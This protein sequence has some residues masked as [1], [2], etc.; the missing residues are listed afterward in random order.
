[1]EDVNSKRKRKEEAKML[2]RKRIEESGGIRPRNTNNRKDEAPTAT[3]AAT[4]AATATTTSNGSKSIITNTDRTTSFKKKQFEPSS[5]HRFGRVMESVPCRKQPRYST[6]SIALPGSVVSNCQTRELKT[7]LVGQIARA[8]AVYHVDEIIV[9][10]DKLAEDK[11]DKGFFRNKHR[12]ETKQREKEEKKEE[13][14]EEEPKEEKKEEPSD[15]PRFKRSDPH[16]FMARVLQYC[17]CPQYLRR[18]FFPMHPDLQFTGLLSPLDSPHHV[19]QEERSKYREGVVMDRK[20][21]KGSLVNCGI[22]NRPV[23]ID[24]VLMAGV[25]VTVQLDVKV[26]GS[27]GKIYGTV[28]SPSAPREDDGTYW[29]YNTRLASSINAV[30]EECPFEGGYDL[31]IG[32]S[33]RGDITVDDKDFGLP[34]FQHSLIVFGGVAGIEECVD[35][36]ESLKVPGSQSRK[37]FDMWV[38][39]C[40]YQ[41]SRTIRTEEAVLISLC[42]LSPYMASNSET[43]GETPHVVAKETE[44][45]NFSDEEPSDESSADGD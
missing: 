13:I 44:A 12:E 29:G 27:A 45:I 19:R 7:Q 40:P 10:D 24:R 30:F 37:L 4:A 25:R 21:A 43:Q 16:T 20:G 36:D 5:K 1:M 35:A 9:F 18:Q 6:L 39:T 33:E 42:R 22:K 2:K 32:T 41:G 28:V 11:N 38:N 34:K 17:E 31:K 14:K 26:Y 15:K 23:E 8:C 3:A